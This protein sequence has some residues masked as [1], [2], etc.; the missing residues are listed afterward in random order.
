VRT[1]AKKGGLIIVVSGPSG[2]GKTTLVE[3]LLGTRELKRK[4]SRSVSLTTRPKRSGERDKKDYF[5]IS[6][7]QFQQARKAKK[8]LEWTRY[9]GYYYATPIERIAEQLKKA[10]NI[11]LCL[12]L[13]GAET[14]KALYPGNTVTV[15]VLPPSQKALLQR[16]TSRCHRTT[17]REVR[18]RMGLAQKELQAASRY[19]YCLVNKDLN[20]AVRQLTGI[21]LGEIR[22]RKG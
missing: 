3:K 19:D 18:E 13:K 10:K 1:K 20:T 4:L 6:G 5:F 16:I 14:M 8:I 22:K 21:I 2:S 9:L 7:K 15:F 12:D 11:I 17:D